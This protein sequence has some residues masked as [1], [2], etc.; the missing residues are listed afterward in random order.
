MTTLFLK[1]A[2]KGAAGQGGLFLAAMLLSI[3]IVPMNADTLSDN[4]SALTAGTEAAHGNTW[5]TASFA[6]GATAYSL[7]SITL[8]L[9]NS[10]PGTAELD[11]YSDVGQPGS[12]LTILTPPASYS[13]S[14]SPTIFLGGAFSLD[15]NSTYWL[16]LKTIGGEFDWAWTASNT[17]S[18]VGFT[19]TWGVSDDAGADWFTSDNNPMQMR[20]AASHAAVPEPGPST[21]VIAG[22]VLL[23]ALCW[24]QRAVRY[25]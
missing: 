18:G 21:L 14:L 16:V 9:A 15:A 17:G 7:S 4:L 24:R 3:G 19:H 13:D 10:V 12:R 8:L 20:V 22:S 11:L 1:A 2:H 6:T 25:C 5:I 23:M